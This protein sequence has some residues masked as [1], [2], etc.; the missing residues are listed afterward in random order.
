MSSSPMTILLDI[1]GTILSHPSSL[2]NCIADKQNVLPGVKEKFACWSRQ[3][4]C[5][6]LITARPE[7]MRSLTVKQIENA[8]LYF[9]HLIMGLPN[10]PRVLI[11]DSKPSADTTAFAYTVK[12]DA[13]L[14]A[15]KC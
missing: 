6:I 2:S 13:G 15:F 14:E 8:G 5:I 3:S 9:D 10:G 4:Y 12:R 7:S 11:N 1:D